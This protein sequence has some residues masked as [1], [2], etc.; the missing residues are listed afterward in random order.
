MKSNPILA[1]KATNNNSL[2]I[3][4]KYISLDIHHQWSNTTKLALF[5]VSLLN[6]SAFGTIHLQNVNVKVLHKQLNHSI[7]GSIQHR[8]NGN[9]AVNY[10][11]SDI[12]ITYYI[13]NKKSYCNSCAF[14]LWLYLNL[15]ISTCEYNDNALQI[16]AIYE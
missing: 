16:S 14:H 9:P 4:L 8:P 7:S 5:C 6:I 3:F 10:L 1:S 12:H 15:Q 13:Q 11:E 2:Q